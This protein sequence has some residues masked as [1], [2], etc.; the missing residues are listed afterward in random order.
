M[1]SSSRT[2]SAYPCQRPVL[3]R[4]RPSKSVMRTWI[5]RRR[6]QQRRRLRQLPR[7]VRS[8]PLPHR[9]SA[10]SSH[11]PQ[12]AGVRTTQGCGVLRLCRATRAERPA[13]IAG[14]RGCRSRGMELTGR[15]WRMKTS[16]IRGVSRTLKIRS[17]D[18]RFTTVRGGYG[19]QPGAT[20]PRPDTLPSAHTNEPLSQVLD[21]QPGPVN[22]EQI[23]SRTCDSVVVPS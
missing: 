23:D 3:S 18:R 4:T 12:S 8:K 5:D 19:I 14:I 6:R 2:M 20:A 9:L 22:P 13:R 7:R 1:T 15:C 21:P 16:G 10:G 11:A 17:S